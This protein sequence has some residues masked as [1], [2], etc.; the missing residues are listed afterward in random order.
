MSKYAFLRDICMDDIKISGLVLLPLDAPIED[1]FCFFINKLKIDQ[2]NPFSEMRISIL[3]FYA[4]I[5]LHGVF[6]GLFLGA[7]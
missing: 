6:T 2:E 7:S 1:I 4:V 5:T 3:A